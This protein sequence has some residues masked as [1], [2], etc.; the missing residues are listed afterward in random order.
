MLVPKGSF[1]AKVEY[2]IIVESNY[3]EAL[4]ELLVRLREGVHW[5]AAEREQFFP[6]ISVALLAV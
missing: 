2:I 3:D 1:R 6:E 5:G 4:Q